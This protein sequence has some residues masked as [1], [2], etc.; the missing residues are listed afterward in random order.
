MPGPTDPDLKDL[1]S[2][3]TPEQFELLLP[4]AESDPSPVV[5]ALKSELTKVAAPSWPTI[6]PGETILHLDLDDSVLAKI[7]AYEGMSTAAFILCQRLPLDQFAEFADQL[8]AFAY[9]PACLRAYQSGGRSWVAAIWMHDRL[10]W[11]FTRHRGAQRIGKTQEEMRKNDLYPIDI[12]AVARADSDR[13]EMEYGILWSEAPPAMID[14]RLYVGLRGE[15]HQSRGWEPLNEGGFVPKSNLKVR[16]ANGH[17]LYSSIRW[18]TVSHSQF[19]DAW[20]DS[21]LEYEDRRQDDWQQADVRINPADEFDERE[22]SYS[23]VWWNGGAM[24]SKSLIRLDH[25]DHLRECQ[26]L[27][28]ENFR[29]VSISVVFDE[30][31]DKL[32]AASVWHRPLV[33]DEDKDVLASRQVN[34][35]IAL[36]RLGMADSLWPLLESQPDSRLRSFLIDRMASMGADPLILWRRLMIEQSQSTKFALIAALAQYRPEQLP[37]AV[38]N[39]LRDTI[40]DWGTQDRSSSIHSICHYLARQWNWKMIDA[41]I[42]SAPSPAQPI[43]ADSPTWYRNSQGQTMVAIAGPV[44]FR[45][46]SPVQEAFRDHHRE[47]SMTTR[48]HRHFAIAAAE[49]TVEQF[50]AFDPAARYSAEYTLGEKNCPM[51][52][53][54]WFDAVNYCRWLS[55]QENVPEDQMCYPSVTDMLVQ[56]ETTNSVTRPD[57]FLQRTGY[58]LPTEA[59][60][61]Y[62]ASRS[63][64]D[65]SPFWKRLRTI[66]KICLDDRKLH[67][68]FSGA[69]PP[70]RATST[71]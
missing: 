66:A 12:T 44:E 46:G 1:L 16:D 22:I 71:Q 61:E 29:P 64:D 27:A 31:R 58:R 65:T 68:P 19:I 35:V 53:V 14:S 39:Q 30:N 23:A 62:C 32:V 5:A 15:E 55:E 51:T 70:H 6:S 11:Q 63:D 8:R 26:K 36:L 52:A 28:K 56:Y 38:L 9:R 33:S 48:I 21:P 18:R 41:A 40:S 43:L 7:V 67:R 3:A 45:T 37:V 2:V 34:A 47:E 60:W 57:N 17:D 49:V 4:I 24:Q 59:E 13:G 42:A 20:N 50:Q 54:N 69:I 10:E 25:G